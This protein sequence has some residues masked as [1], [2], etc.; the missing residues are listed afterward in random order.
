MLE[1]KLRRQSNRRSSSSRKEQQQ[2]LP[3]VLLVLAFVLGTCGMIA[4]VPMVAIGSHSIYHR[5]DVILIRAKKTLM[6]QAIVACNIHGTS[7]GAR[8]VLNFKGH[9]S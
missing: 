8:T 1:D 6:T 7:P 2:H 5:H 9:V 3:P 4:I